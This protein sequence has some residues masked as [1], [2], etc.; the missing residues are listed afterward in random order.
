[1]AG[2]GDEDWDK[3][4]DFDTHRLIEAVDEVDALR[5][6]LAL[7]QQSCHQPPLRRSDGE[8]AA[9]DK[10]GSALSAS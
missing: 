9:G 1:M 5:G 10:S 7:T 4:Q 2:A 6:M 8:Q 3:L